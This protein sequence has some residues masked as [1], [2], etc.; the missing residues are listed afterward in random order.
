LQVGASAS[1]YAYTGREWDPEIELHYYRARYYSATDGRFISEDPIRF[2]GG[3]NFF[4]YVGNDPTDSIDPTGECPCS[5]TVRCRG[6]HDWRA[7]LG[8]SKH[9]YIVAS[10]PSGT[11]TFTA[12]PSGPGGKSLAAWAIPGDP[13]PGNKTSNK[14]YYE[15][16]SA[17]CAAL[18]CLESKT[19]QFNAAGHRYKAIKGPNSNSFVQWIMGECVGHVR[20][21]RSA[22]GKGALGE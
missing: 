14:T 2:F 15:N 17:D 21:P 19:A 6:V 16:D 20:L 11:T 8:F 4:T 3:I 13:A 5:I 18:E 10:G 7:K 12:G 1:G 22:W 9:C